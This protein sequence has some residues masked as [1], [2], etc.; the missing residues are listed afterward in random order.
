[1]KSIEAI[2]IQDI[3]SHSHVARSTFYR[4]FR[5][6]YDVMNWYY[7]A[8]VD[9]LL[10]QYEGIDWKSVMYRIIQFLFDD[11]V[12]FRKMLRYSSQI[13]FWNFIYDYGY[14][15]YESTILI[16]Q[17]RKNLTTDEKYILGSYCNGTVHILKQWITDG[18][19]ET[20][21]YITDLIYSLI[22][23]EIENSLCH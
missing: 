23:K 19:N 17:G 13:T 4:Y 9:N 5:D 20:V 8:Y 14:K 16:Q 1:M 2:T 12:Y 15:F 22:P 3:L 11:A 7:Q 6:K 21:E 10:S 18:C